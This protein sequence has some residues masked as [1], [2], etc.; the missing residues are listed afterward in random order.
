MKLDDAGTWITHIGKHVGSTTMVNF[1]VF[2]AGFRHGAPPSADAVRDYVAARISGLPYFKCRV[3][4]TPLAAGSSRLVPVADFDV[5]NHVT[6]RTAP[7]SG[8]WVELRDELA[9]IRETS[10]DPDLPPW[11]ITVFTGIR[12]IPGAAGEFLGVVTQLD[13]SVTDGAGSVALGR[14]LFPEA[15]VTEVGVGRKAAILTPSGGNVGLLAD[16]VAQAP[17]RAARFARNLREAVAARGKNASADD[18]APTEMTPMR[19]PAPQTAID[20]AGGPLGYRAFAA[21]LEDIQRARA[22]VPGATINDVLISAVGGALRTYLRES[23]PLPDA[24]LRCAITVATAQRPHSPFVGNDFTMAAVPFGVHLESSRDRLAYVAGQT[25]AVKH[26]IRTGPKVPVERALQSIPPL[27]IPKVLA[28]L[29]GGRAAVNAAVVNVPRGSRP[30]YFGEARSVASFGLPFTD[31][32]PLAH[33]VTTL[34]DVV[35]VNAL[36]DSASIRD[37]DTYIALLE[38]E[39]SELVKLGV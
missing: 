27:F 14:L 22:T 32:V 33:A 12:E 28:M 9:R 1:T 20:S 31:G 13:H 26:R 36:Y 21:S 18:R 23:G 4:R 34:G 25:A 30:M 11:H 38:S 24:D 37:G 2:D 29:S 5:A 15:P 10:L 39:L 16:A 8:G 17:S 7:G 3:A 35:T 19:G 6:L